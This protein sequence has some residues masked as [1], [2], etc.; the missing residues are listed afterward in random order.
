MHSKSDSIK[1]TTYDIPEQIIEESFESLL[2]RYQIGLETKMICFNLM[3]HKCHKIRFKHG[4][5][6][7]DSPD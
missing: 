1:V 3:H 7:I 5:S 4:A 6:Y 2:S